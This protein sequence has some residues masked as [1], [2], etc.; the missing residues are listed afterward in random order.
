MFHWNLVIKIS[1]DSFR[2]K[3]NAKS[4]G[5][6]CSANKYCMHDDH[7]VYQSVDAHSLCLMLQDIKLLNIIAV[8]TT[9]LNVNGETLRLVTCLTKGQ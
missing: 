3:Y 1:R 5:D 6:R 4:L 2:T 8:I 9:V 7:Y